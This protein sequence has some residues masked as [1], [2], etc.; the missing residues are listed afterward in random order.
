MTLAWR[1]LA[2]ALALGGVAFRW[3]ELGTW[4][5]SNDE[6]WV[7]LATRVEGLEQFWLAIAMTPVGWAALVKLASVAPGDGELALRTVPFAFGCLTLWG[8]FRAGRRFAGHELGG[9]LALAVVAFEPLGVSYAKLLKQYTAE[10]FFCIL[11]IDCAAAF[12]E[13]RRRRDLVVLALVL[14]GG[15]AF[16][17]SQL[18]L[19]PPIFAA[20]LL[21]ALRRGDRRQLRD[22]V[23]ATTVVG[24][25]D[26]LH[27]RLVLGPRL[28]SAL[29][30]YWGAQIYLPLHPT[31]AA[32]I[33]W[34][35]LRWTLG[36]ALGQYAFPA[37]M[38][39]LA[40]ASTLPSQRTT[41]LLLALL[42]L[43]LAVLSMLGV[44][45][46]SQPRI[47]IFLTTT[48]G[49]FAG[50][51]M[52][53][54]LVRAAASR[55]LAPV[56]AVGLAFLAHDFVRAHAWHALSRSTQVEDA[57]PLVREFERERQPTDVLLLHQT[58]LFIYGYYQAATPVLLRM[59]LS[60][61]YVP[62][63]ADPRV[64]LVND[65]DVEAR[66]R[67]ALERSPRVWLVASRLRPPREKRIRDS[68]ARVASPVLERRRPGAL[69]M[70]LG[71]RP[72]GG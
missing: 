14:T 34:A 45:A 39:C 64:V 3:S 70:L 41:G 5:L 31:D 40:V 49:A 32:P 72:A 13:R 62:R 38:A 16:A 51:A 66:A 43:E 4:G 65:P 67:E 50:A 29:D 42:V 63:L 52:A 58:T 11:A 44:V 1:V 55:I 47:L 46:V 57:G 53:L 56:A 19:A 10:A 28:P 8:A 20:L 2:L 9:I 68:V 61:G 33:L 59:P 22:L 6:A 7:G 18:F 25:V 69:L 15:L 23:L 24:V 54:L 26:L 36:P 60:V 37:G 30:E 48:L 21:D 35:R 17:N 27:Y 12:A 71:R